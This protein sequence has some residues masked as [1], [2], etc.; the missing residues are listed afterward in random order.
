MNC[1]LDGMC[2]RVWLF[3]HMDGDYAAEKLHETRQRI[4]DV[5]RGARQ[6]NFSFQI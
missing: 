5:A 4:A 3:T 6:H 1:R 2:E